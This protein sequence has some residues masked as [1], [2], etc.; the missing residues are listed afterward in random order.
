MAARGGVSPGDARWPHTGPRPACR[1]R[2][3][4]LGAVRWRVACRRKIDVAWCRAVLLERM[5]LG[6]CC[7]TRPDP[8]DDTRVGRR[9]LWFLGR[10]F[11][12]CHVLSCR[13][14]PSP[15]MFCPIPTR[16]GS[17]RL[18]R[19]VEHNVDC[20]ISGAQTAAHRKSSIVAPWETPVIRWEN[21][22]QYT[23]P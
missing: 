15:A 20:G 4:W 7:E 18:P 10:L 11:L 19:R 8:Q 21:T 13:V 3:P 17:A 14:L 12:S 22:V 9:L 6:V 2:H 23:L 5:A 1:W 16:L